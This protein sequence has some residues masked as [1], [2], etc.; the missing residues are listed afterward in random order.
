LARH[1][2]VPAAELQDEIEELT[3]AL[4]FDLVSRTP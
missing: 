4:E 1:D 3:E 2:T